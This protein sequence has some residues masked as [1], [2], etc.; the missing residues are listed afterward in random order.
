MPLNPNFETSFVHTPATSHDYAVAI[1]AD[2]VHTALRPLRKSALI[3]DLK[4]ERLSVSSATQDGDIYDGQIMFAMKVSASLPP[5]RK[6]IWVPVFIRSGIVN[7][8]R[9]FHDSSGRKYAL[10]AEGLKKHLGI[11]MTQ[12]R[13]LKKMPHATMSFTD[14]TILPSLPARNFFSLADRKKADRVRIEQEFNNREWVR[15]ID[16]TTG[17]SRYVKPYSSKVTSVMEFEVDGDTPRLSMRSEGRIMTRQDIMD[18]GNGIRPEAQGPP[19]MAYIAEGEDDQEEEETPTALPQEE[20]PQEPMEEPEPEMSPEDSAEL[21]EALTDYFEN[22]SSRLGGRDALGQ[23]IQVG[24][25]VK[26]VGGRKDHPGYYVAQVFGDMIEIERM[27]QMSMV[28]GSKYEIVPGGQ[29]IE[30]YAYSDASSPEFDGVA[31]GLEERWVGHEDPTTSGREDDQGFEWGAED[32]EEGFEEEMEHAESVPED[33]NVADIAIDHL[34]QDPDYYANPERTEASGE[35]FRTIMKHNL[36]QCADLNPC[37]HC[38]TAMPAGYYERMYNGVRYA[39]IA[40]SENPG[41]WYWKVADSDH[42]PQDWQWGKRDAIAAAEDFIDSGERPSTASREANALDGDMTLVVDGEET[43]PEDLTG[44]GVYE[45]IQPTPMV[46]MEDD[47]KVETLEGPMN[48]DEG[49]FLAM[50]PEGE[51]YPVDQEIQNQT[52]Q[53][54]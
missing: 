25:M 23:D 13:Q 17:Q 20:L 2:K 27:D 36:G 12:F 50:G 39:V 9:E 4:F 29:G 40:V 33:E 34:E 48:A 35:Q 45:K 22:G 37:P 15:V 26:P 5:H 3:E 46:Q 30:R 6:M 24:N 14:R 7:D 11:E 38:R 1:A 44:W 54:I 31:D 41:W 49:D 10:D 8:P 51:L 42:V 19:E 52:Y 28:S 47:F 53:E 43:E 21:E 18:Y 32:L 16:V